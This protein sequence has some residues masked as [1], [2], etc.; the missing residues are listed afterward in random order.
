MSNGPRKKVCVVK[1]YTWGIVSQDSA[2][3]T[4]E[5][6]ASSLRRATVKDYSS[7]EEVLAADVEVVDRVE[8]DQRLGRF[9]VPDVVVFPSRGAVEA[10]KRIAAQMP[11]MKVVVLTGAIPDG[12]VLFVDKLWDVSTIQ[13]AILGH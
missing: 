11:R 13:E 9:P 7:G 1:G 5:T 12:E 2:D 8:L 3:E 10:A 6:M 4:V